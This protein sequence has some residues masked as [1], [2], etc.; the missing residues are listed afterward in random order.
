M[1]VFLCFCFLSSLLRVPLNPSGKM[2]ISQ[3]Y[4]YLCSSLPH[5]Y[6]AQKGD[7]VHSKSTQLYPNR[8]IIACLTVY[9]PFFV[10]LRLKSTQ[11]RTATAIQLSLSST[12]W[13]MMLKQHKEVYTLSFLPSVCSVSVSLSCIIDWV[14]FILP[15][16]SLK[17]FSYYSSPILLS[18]PNFLII[19][20]PIEWRV[21][22]NNHRP[23]FKLFLPLSSSMRFLS[24]LQP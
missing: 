12:T 5:Y 19:I 16:V 11:E 9:L 4:I 23:S 17:T 1:S 24:L 10:A 13:I 14:S 7:K 8:S 21:R 22:A 20:M 18:S 3:L 2:S 15:F 6:F